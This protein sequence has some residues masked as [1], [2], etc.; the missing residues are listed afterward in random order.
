MKRKLLPFPASAL[1][2]SFSRKKWQNGPSRFFSNQLLVDFLRPKDD[3]I[4]K[5]GNHLLLFN[6]PVRPLYVV[7]GLWAKVAGSIGFWKHEDANV[8]FLYMMMHRGLWTFCQ[9]S[10][11][12]RNVCFWTTTTTYDLFNIN[13]WIFSNFSIIPFAVHDL[14]HYFHRELDR[15]YELLQPN[16]W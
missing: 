12:C 2:A 10:A 4:H 6:D 9:S 3:F 11:N 14:Q 16:F 13:N 15:L 7:H 8:E 5:S 1:P